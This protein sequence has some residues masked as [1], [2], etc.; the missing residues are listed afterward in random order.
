MAQG[1]VITNILNGMKYCGI[2][3]K[4][5]KSYI[6]RFEEH[7]NGRGGRILFTEGINKHGSSN[8]VCD[9]IVEGELQEI[10][11][12]ENVNAKSN[13]WPVGYNGNAGRVIIN[14]I[15]TR[16][17]ARETR[18]RKYGDY[19]NHTLGGKTWN[20]IHGDDKSSKLKDIKRH[21]Q[22][23]KTMSER[24][25]KPEWTSPRRGSNLSNETKDRIKQSAR[26][27]KSSTVSLQNI[28]TNEIKSLFIYEWIET[29]NL[30]GQCIS[31]MKA[32]KQQTHKD[33][34]FI[35]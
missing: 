4:S 20:E 21:F 29:Y 16:A 24:I 15:E 8:F 7:K 34:K 22:T 26:K 18:E 1:Y 17:K 10:R 6:E 5:G 27:T 30:I 31:A 14:T 11:E 2:I 12:W 19:G 32:G 28:K 13:L 23:G 3:Y 9:L 33:W 35:Q 25:K